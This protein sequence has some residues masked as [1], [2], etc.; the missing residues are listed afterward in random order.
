MKLAILRPKTPLEN[1]SWFTTFLLI[2]QPST[3]YSGLYFAISLAEFPCSVSTTI[4]EHY[5][6]LAVW[7]ALRATLSPVETSP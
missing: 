3:A 1:P 5:R 2:E 4:K 6:T 7:T